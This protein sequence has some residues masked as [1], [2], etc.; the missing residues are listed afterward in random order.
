[1]DREERRKFLLGR[2]GIG[3]SQAGMILGVSEFGG[4]PDAFREI[5]KTLAGNITDEDLESTPDQER[6]IMF[7]PVA[8]EKYEM[9]TGRK[10]RRVGQR[11]HPDHDFIIDNPDRMI[12]TFDDQGTGALEIKCPRWPAFK[13]LQDH[14]LRDEYLVQMQHHLAVTGW[15]WGSFCAF[16]ADSMKVIYFDVERND[17]F[18]DDILIPALVN[19]WQDHI[20]LGIEPDMDWKPTDLTLLPTIGGEVAVLDSQ[21]AIDLGTLYLEVVEKRKEFTATE[22][23]CRESIAK[24]ATGHGRIE[25]PGVL[26]ATPVKGRMKWVKGGKALFDG[27]VAAAGIDPDNH[28]E[29]GD[30]YWKF[31]AIKKNDDD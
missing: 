19:F 12:V 9:A 23:M 15:L 1:M 16:H 3:S 5:R 27:E 18:I 30:P 22:R 4:P 10:L 26:T 7:E 11:R 14:G 21:Q 28:K 2:D 17:A 8:A 13:K 20:V 31:T 25:I 6:G 24:M 29:A